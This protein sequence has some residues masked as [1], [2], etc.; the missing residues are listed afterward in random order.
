MSDQDAFKACTRS[1]SQL[2]WHLFLCRFR[3]T[4]LSKETGER[5]TRWASSN[6]EEVCFDF[7]THHCDEVK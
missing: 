1:V 6:D 4:I 3:R 5:C 7:G 2:Q